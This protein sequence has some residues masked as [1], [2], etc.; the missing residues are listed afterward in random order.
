MFATLFAGGL[1]AVAGLFG[2]SDAKATEKRARAAHEEAERKNRKAVKKANATNEALGRELLNVPLETTTV[3]Q[4]SGGVKTSFR[5]WGDVDSVAMMAAAEASGFNPVT[6]LNAGGMTAYARRFYESNVEDTTRI[7]TT[8]TSKGHNA[9]A[10]YQLM[11]PQ[12]YQGTPAPVHN[13]PSVGSVLAQAG[14]DAF[15]QYNDDAI[16][17]ASQ[18]FQRELMQMQLDAAQQRA[19]RNKFGD[20]PKTSTSGSAFSAGTMIGGLSGANVPPAG[21]TA[22]WPSTWKAGETSATNPWSRSRIDPNSADAEMFETRYGE[23]LSE[24]FGVRNAV[25]DL[26]AN[27][28]GLTKEQRYARTRDALQK[29]INIRPAKSSS[30][31]PSLSFVP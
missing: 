2:R 10:A 4:R 19:M 31:W 5:E 21:G 23:I 22:G 18:N 28:T 9:A 14:S 11:S 1:S 3:E 24:L 13:V 15:K 25:D 29:L 30:W 20:T 27:A 7:E 26:M 8:F 6:W 17:T 16:R 12:V